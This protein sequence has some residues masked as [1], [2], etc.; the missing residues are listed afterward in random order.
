M[1][2]ILQICYNPS[3]G[4]ATKARACEGVGWEEAQESHFLL[5]GVWESVREWTLALPSE[6]PLWELESQWTPKSS[7]RDC[8]GQNPLD[9]KFMYI[10]WK[11]LKLRC[12]KWAHMTHL[13]T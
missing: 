6:L 10:I 2:L 12:L 5:L 13:D 3:F 1:V 11:F 4:F 9:Q 8:K 7:K